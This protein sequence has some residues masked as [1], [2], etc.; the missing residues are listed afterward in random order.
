MP[1]CRGYSPKKKDKKINPLVSVCA[2]QLPRVGRVGGAPW[3][4]S[5][6]HPGMFGGNQGLASEIRAALQ[7]EAEGLGGKETSF[8]LLPH[9]TVCILFSTRTLD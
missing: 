8:H 5:V 1:T 7:S 4:T 9:G 3:A 2:S 6:S